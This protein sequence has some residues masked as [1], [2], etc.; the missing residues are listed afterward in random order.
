MAVSANEAYYLG[1]AVR[2]CPIDR[3]QCQALDVTRGSIGQMS[4]TLPRGIWSVEMEYR[5]P[6]E[7]HSWF[8]FW[9]AVGG[10]LLWACVVKLLSTRGFSKDNKTQGFLKG[11]IER[12]NTEMAAVP[13]ELF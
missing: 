9:S 11:K 8:L 1:W 5:L 6:Y 13:K 12:G 3:D 10:I 4:F 7:I 2:A